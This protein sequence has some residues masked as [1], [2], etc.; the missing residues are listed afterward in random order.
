MSEIEVFHDPIAI[1]VI[2]F[3]LIIVRVFEIKFLSKE[4]EYEDPK[5]RAII[6]MIVKEELKNELK[7][8]KHRA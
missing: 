3:I 4:P 8:L 1:V 2:V 6:R 7:K 5:L